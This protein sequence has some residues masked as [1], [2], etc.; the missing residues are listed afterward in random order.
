MRDYESIVNKIYNKNKENMEKFNK[1][2]LEYDLLKELQAQISETIIEVQDREG[3]LN[4][5]TYSIGCTMT[6]ATMSLK[7][8]TEHDY[9]ELIKAV[10]SLLEIVDEIYPIYHPI[11]E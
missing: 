2:S 1:D 8:E 6:I 3:A 11:K 7:L 10:D 5:I 9:S 4:M